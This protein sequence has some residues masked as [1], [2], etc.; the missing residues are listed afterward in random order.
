MP[1]ERGDERERAARAQQVHVVEDEQ[2]RALRREQ[3]RGSAPGGRAPECP[4]KGS[5]QHAWVVV[6]VVERH[7]GART[8]R[9]GG[10]LR[11]E[12][13][14]AVPGRSADR[15]ERR[16]RCAKPVDER[17]SV[18]VLGTLRRRPRIDLD[19]VEI[20]RWPPRRRCL[21]SRHVES[22]LRPARPTRTA[23]RTASTCT[24]AQ[25]APDVQGSVHRD[26][27]GART[28]HWFDRRTARRPMR[29]LR[30]RGPPSTL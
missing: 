21:T 17:R 15:D 1:G 28:G 5:E 20:R 25:T 7:P 13:R 24:E 6:T 18:N 11:E 10:P 22:I 19:E 8:A 2:D 4:G 27:G 9:A 16:V 30:A 29:V 23:R 12:R 14:L 26:L 3:R